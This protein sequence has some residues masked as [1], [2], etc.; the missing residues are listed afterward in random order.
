AYALEDVSERRLL[1]ADRLMMQRIFETTLDLI[2]VVDR[3]GGIIQVSPSS[4]GI[5]GYSPEEMI[6]RSAGDYLYA[7]D[8]NSTR[9]EMRRSRRG[10]RTSSF[11]CRY[12]HKDG[13]IVALTWTGIWSE[14]EQRHFFIGRD[15]TERR[16]LEQQLYQAQKMEA[17]GQLTGGMSHDFNNL[18]G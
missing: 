6:G 13:R 2:L 5:L 1:E 4:V 7:E 17:L 16:R 3:R 11:E 9:E 18:L 10:Q 14:S 15:M 8:L 12:V